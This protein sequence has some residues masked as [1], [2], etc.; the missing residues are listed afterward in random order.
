[1][2]TL[3]EAITGRLRRAG[4]SYSSP[5]LVR[6]RQHNERQLAARASEVDD[7]EAKAARYREHLRNEALK[8]RLTGREASV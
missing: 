5:E 6:I 4:L 8:R 7:H 2:T 3:A 1:M